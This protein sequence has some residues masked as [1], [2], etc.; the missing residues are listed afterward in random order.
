MDRTR[1]PRSWETQGKPKAERRYLRLLRRPAGLFSLAFLI[2]C[3]VCAIWADAIS[4]YDPND[5]GD[6]DILAALQGP[7]LKHPLGT[8]SFGGD[9][10][11]SL[12]HI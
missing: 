2:L 8:D 5:P 10:L 9:V 3:V 4:P 6:K 7:S 11:L 12:I 1:N